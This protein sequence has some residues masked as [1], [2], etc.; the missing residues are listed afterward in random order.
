MQKVCVFGAG[1]V[2][3]YMAASL[4]RAG[5]EVS[6]VARGQQLAAIR[7]KGLRVISADD[8]FT[9][10]LPASDNPADLGPQD[11]VIST[12]KAQFLGSA[13]HQMSQLFHASTAVVYAVNGIPWWYFYGIAENPASRLA[14]L[15]PNGDLWGKI[16]PE[17]VLGCVI[18]SPNEIIE[19]GVIRSTKKTSQ[20]LLGEPDGSLSG[21][22]QSVVQLMQ[23]GLPG[24]VGTTSIR[25]EIWSKLLVNLPSSLLSTLTV[26]TSPELFA[27]PQVREIYRQIADE[28][29][30]IAAAYD[31]QIQFDVDAQATYAGTNR[32]PPSML[33]DLL[34]G[35]P[36]E[37]NAQILA[38]QDLARDA[39]VPTPMIDITATL[40]G[41]RARSTHAGHKPPA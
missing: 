19:P 25:S 13:A 29:C 28:T 37:L 2:G 9:V 17:R 15:D 27:E 40:L 41:Q 39:G 5:V 33:Q 38:V 14:R 26:S 24:T 36:L 21:R 11:V 4:A 20:F 10:M 30:R 12:V 3:G 23:Q 34:A 1:A 31:V 6:V 22:L 7:A 8:D 35:K 32:H 18:R 16:G